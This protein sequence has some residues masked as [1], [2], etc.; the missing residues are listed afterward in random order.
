MIKFFRKIRLNSLSEGKTRKYLKYAIGEIILL[1]VGILIALQVNN[2]N[3]RRNL[4]NRTIES[5]YSLTNELKSNKEIL[6]SNIDIV[7]F[8]IRIG[9]NMIDSLNNNTISEEKKDSFLLNKVADLGPLRT[10]SLTT[11]S[12]DEMINSGSYSSIMSNNVK[13]YLLGYHSEIENVDFALNRFEEYWKDIELPY[14][15]KHFSILDMYIKRSDNLKNE[16]T[17]LTGGKIPKFN[18]KELYFSSDPN[19][20]YNNREFASMNTSRFF[21]L[22]SVLKAM[23]N[24]DKS[25]DEVLNKINK[26]H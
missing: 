5:L 18:Y 25:I 26:T 20:F 6:K 24:L 17:I 1:V 9:L 19:A 12:L 15:T 21:D 16:D 14:L 22:R 10:K 23:N 3:E 8:Q 11:T 4:E 7:K 13:Y 2:W